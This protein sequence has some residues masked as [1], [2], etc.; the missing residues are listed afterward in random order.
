M[1]RKTTEGWLFDAYPE[2]EG[3]R[4]W[5]IERGGGRRSVLDC[6]RPA[7]HAGGDA[8][9]LK[10]ISD[11][12]AGLPYPVETAWVDKKELFSD[13]TL[14]VLEIRVPVLERDRL[15]KRLVAMEFALYDADMHLVQAYHYD[16]GHFPLA[17][18]RFRLDG[19][20]LSSFEL[21]DDPWSVDYEIPSLRFLHLS[22]SGSDIAGRVDPNHA[23]FGRLSLTMD[24]RT[25]ELEGGARDQL[26]TLA[27]RLRV[28]DPDVVT[29]DWGDSVLMPELERLSNEH[30][31][32]LGFSRDQG[33]GVEG[34]KDR[35]FFT[36]GRA[37]Y[38][39]GARYFFGRWHLDGKNSFM[40]RETDTDGL[41]EI[42]RIAKIPVQRAAR[43]T[44]GTS[45]SSM[46]MAWASTHGVLIPM[47]KQ[48]AE[49]FRPAT[50]LLAADKGGLVYEPDVGWHR[51]VA[52]Y[53]F[54]SMYPEM[55]VRRNISP[56]TV[57]CPCCPENAV[58]EV[59][60]H[61]CTK[62]RGLVPSVLEPILL[63]RARYKALAKAG[64]PDAA[65]YKRRAAAHKWCLV[66]CFGYL[67][68][69]N[70]RFGKIEAHECV[71]AWGRE[72]LLRA[73]DSVESRGYRLLH[74]LVDAIWIELRPGADLEE[75]RLLIEREAECPLALEG[76]YEWI[77][78]C[79]SKEDALSG[80]PGRYF[81]AFT[82][83]ELKI[84]GIAL[85]RR[86]TPSLLKAMQR[87]LLERL[88]RVEPG[89]DLKALVPALLDI[90]SDYRLRLREGRVTAEELAI[91][92][93][94]SREP[95]EYVHDTVSSLAA[96]QLAATGVTLH[97][98]E[99]V[100]YVITAASDAVKEWRSKP[101]ALMEHGLEYDAKKYLEL[102]ER[103]AWE[104]LDGLV[105]P[106]APKRRPQA[107]K[108]PELPL[109]WS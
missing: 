21:L 51:N 40:L 13:A 52:E 2:P 54:T 79:P 75:L 35:S 80:V 18:C 99:T 4:V 87:E 60:H 93:H 95:G 24:G 86:D 81:G 92:F 94:L 1:P 106:P 78:Y 107:V 102:L 97:A 53:D 16:R 73:K 72:V 11:I 5:I 12:L 7:F 57:N 10:R 100:R 105:P 56:E 76:V 83:G 14:R 29:S 46:Q 98:G 26:E 20:I 3:M 17:L 47:E 63:K 9:A 103:A 34:K 19:G 108:P 33:R 41:F 64:G 48:Q 89:G 39:G 27:R 77:R 38:Q 36:Y 28:F 59:G 104:V 37:V 50:E 91:T 67:G 96:K 61:L 58:P 31:I 22:L 15:V 109:L 101:L 85:R 65:S 66:T 70:A 74:A 32:P 6:W 62:R 55:M 90:V 69:K 23:A 8:R 88:A 44:I 25:S 71:T 84:R 49:D 42:A 68:F 45:L 82:N 30:R 43:C